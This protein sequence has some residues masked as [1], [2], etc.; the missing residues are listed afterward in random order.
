MLFGREL[1]RTHPW[2]AFS[3]TEDVEYWIKLRGAGIA[4]KFAGGA[5]LRSPTAPT[6]KAAAEQQ[7]RWEG[8]KFHVARAQI[9]KLVAAAVRLRRA[10][11]LDSAVELAM[12]PLGLLTAA[13]LAGTIA[14]V[15]LLAVDVVP[16]WSAAPWLVALVAI[17]LYVLLGLRAAHAPASS[18]RALASAPALVATKLMRVHRLFT[19]RAD[20]WVRTDRGGNRIR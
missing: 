15:A 1:L 8:G 7:L 18:Y 2:D 3:S 11:L 12:P 6:S 9:P 20:S 16:I 13:A 4:P 17:P 14:S 10:S 5:V 19:F